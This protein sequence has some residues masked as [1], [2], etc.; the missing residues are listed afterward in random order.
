MESYIRSVAC[1]IQHL[2]KKH[3][4]NFRPPGYLIFRWLV[5]LKVSSKYPHTIYS[6]YPTHDIHLKLVGSSDGGIDNSKA[7]LPQLASKLVQLAD[8]KDGYEFHLKTLL[9]L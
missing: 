9:S 8:N 4:F 7:A 1:V 3:V 5:I 2:K 6:Q